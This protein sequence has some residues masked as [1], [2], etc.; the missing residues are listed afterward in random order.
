MYTSFRQQPAHHLVGKRIFDRLVK[1]GPV[2]LAIELRHK[3]RG[4]VRTSNTTITTATELCLYIYI[5]IYSDLA[6]IWI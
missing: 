1:Y 2:L 6:Y 3:I 4:I 5:Y